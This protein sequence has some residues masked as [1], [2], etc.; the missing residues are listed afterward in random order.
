MPN[1]FGDRLQPTLWLGS[2]MFGWFKRRGPADDRTWA[3]AQFRK[4][5]DEIESEPE[6]VQLG[7]AIVLAAYWKAFIAVHQSP[8]HFAKL[9]RDQQMDYFRKL[10]LLQANLVE[11]NELEKAIPLEMLG[12]FIGAI[13]NEDYAFEQEAATFLE[14]YARKGWDIGS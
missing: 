8:A 4:R 7:F 13:I 1:G 3:I 2:A 10:M 14:P 11:R 6:E 9:P 12:L 5:R